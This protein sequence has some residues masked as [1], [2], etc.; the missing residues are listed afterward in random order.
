MNDEDE[1][2]WT[3]NRKYKPDCDDPCFVRDRDGEYHVARFDVVPR[4][5]L[6]SDLNVIDVVKWMYPPNEEE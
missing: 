5:W 6:D 1:L 2:N 3:P 4:I